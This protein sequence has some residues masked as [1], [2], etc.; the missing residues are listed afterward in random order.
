MI[1]ATLGFLFSSDWQH[2]L[3]IQKNRPAW[4]QGKINGLGG[5]C[6][7]TET[8]AQCVSREVQ[9]ESGLLIPVEEWKKVGDVFWAEWEV[10][11]L[12]AQYSGQISDP[13]TQTDEPVAWYSVANLP[14]EVMSNL[15]WLIPLSQDV[16]T[17]SS[18]LSTVAKYTDA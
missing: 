16:L 7:G 3:L 8:P 2:V 6:E 5:K 4:Q 18:S 13:L 1:K 9:E 14:L 11:V 15:R 10:S 17:N 12:A